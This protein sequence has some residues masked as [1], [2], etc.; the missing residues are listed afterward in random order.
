[1]QVQVLLC[2]L[3]LYV[4]VCVTLSSMCVFVHDTEH[5]RKEVRVCVCVC[6]CPLHS[7]QEESDLTTPE[8]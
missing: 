6:V 1:M 4:L 2:Q 8:R 5:C 3:T 7:R